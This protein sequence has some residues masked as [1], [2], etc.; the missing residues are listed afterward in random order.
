MCQ[1]IKGF[2]FLKETRYP[3]DEVRTENLT[4]QHTQ[5]IRRIGL[6]VNE[7]PA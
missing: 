1:K 6:E 7:F 5:T 2:Q 4:E 3:E